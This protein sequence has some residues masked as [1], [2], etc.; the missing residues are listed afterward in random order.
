MHDSMAQERYTSFAVLMHWAVAG[1]V[2]CQLGLG[3][4]LESL[5]K[6]PDRSAYFALHKSVGLTVFLLAALRLVWRATHPPPPLPASMPRWQGLLARG[7]HGLLYALI[8][9]QP[10]SG[11]LS[12]SFS[13]YRTSFFGFPLPHW[14]WK[15]PFL[16]ELF[17]DI[18]EASAITL[19]VLVGVHVLAAV[20]HA[21][22]PGDP[23]FRR[24]LPRSL[25]P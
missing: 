15:E 4:Y 17:S 9:L 18:H 10:A 8:F 14:G 21:V 25:V 2:F 5:P 24:M 13:G 19:A 6:G 22:R 23:L 7:N 1:L 20:A 12:S 11:Y 3:S 16:N